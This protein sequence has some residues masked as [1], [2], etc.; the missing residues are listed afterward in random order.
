MA[1]LELVPLCHVEL[2]LAAP[3]MVGEGPSGTRIVADITGMALTGERLTASLKGAGAADWLTVAGS[4]ATVDVRATL[5]TDDGALVSVSY[6]GRSDVSGGIGTA[7][8]FVAPRFETGDERYRWLNAVQAVGK[9]LLADRSYDW[10][11]LR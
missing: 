2:T 6:A 7:P 10:Y 1:T 4:V 9:G 5:E 3:H 8:F 11:E